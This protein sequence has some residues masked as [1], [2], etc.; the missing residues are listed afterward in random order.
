MGKYLQAVERY[1]QTGSEEELGRPVSE[2][3]NFFPSDPDNPEV[4]V[5]EGDFL[6]VYLNPDYM[7]PRLP[8]HVPHFIAIRLTA[9]GAEGT[10]PWEIRFRERISGE[11]DFK[12]LRG[13]IGSSRPHA[14]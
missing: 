10:H 8:H 4:R 5:R 13:L 1:L 7:D 2:K 11:L 9:K 12:A 14:E 6:M 3:L